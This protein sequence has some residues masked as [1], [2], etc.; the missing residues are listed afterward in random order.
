MIR[1]LQK[2]F[3]AKLRASP[4]TV[5]SGNASPIA[6]HGLQPALPT[7]KGSSDKVMPRRQPPAKPPVQK[8]AWQTWRQRCCPEPC[9]TDWCPAVNP[10]PSPVPQ[11]RSGATWNA[12]TR[13]SWFVGVTASE[14]HPAVNPDPSPQQGAQ[15]ANCMNELRG[16]TTVCDA[17]DGDQL[18]TPI[19][20]G[21]G[22]VPHR[23]S[24]QPS[25]LYRRLTCKT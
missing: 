3:G 17:A 15:A 9:T 6:T 23:N 1:R 19:S 22:P 12:R 18:V 13:C 20:C 4:D 8:E 7:S 2:Q 14:P 16:G 25:P 11:R 24:G 5:N 10:D 21:L